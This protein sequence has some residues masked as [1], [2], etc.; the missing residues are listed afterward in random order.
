M[1]LKKDFTTLPIISFSALQLHLPLPSRCITVSSSSTIF[2]FI[3][4]FWCYFLLSSFY[5]QVIM[6]AHV[7]PVSPCRRG[8]IYPKGYHPSFI[9]LVLSSK[10]SP[11]LNMFLEAVKKS[12]VCSCMNSWLYC[13]FHHL[14][15][16]CIISI[17]LPEPFKWTHWCLF[18]KNYCL[19]ETD[20]TQVE[21]YVFSPELSKFPFEII[22]SL[23]CDSLWESIA[24]KETKRHVCFF[25]TAQYFILTSNF[26]WP[27]QQSFKSRLWL[28]S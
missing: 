27:R 22:Y 23:F 14:P 13:I 17:P 24:L 2:T 4:I 11:D 10:T 6:I 5:C 21:L 8:S 26:P 3:S 15:C 25:H 12:N 16:Y 20:A 1:G 7:L 18:L 28:K 19:P 9:Y